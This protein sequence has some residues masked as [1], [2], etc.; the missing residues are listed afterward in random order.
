MEGR[1]AKHIAL[2]KFTHNTLFT[3]R[4]VQ[5]FKQKYIQ[6][7]WFVL[8]MNGYDEIVYKET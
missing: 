8:R 4:W 2:A 3:N 5:V 6:Y 1:E 7:L